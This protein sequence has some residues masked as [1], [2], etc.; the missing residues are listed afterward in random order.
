MNQSRCMVSLR[1]QNGSQAKIGEHGQGMCSAL[2]SGR[3]NVP[4]RKGM[5]RSKTQEQG[6]HSKWKLYLA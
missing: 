6:G 4:I 5:G 3:G 2:K 1:K